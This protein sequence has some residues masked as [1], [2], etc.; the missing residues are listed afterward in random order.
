[1]TCLGKDLREI[2]YSCRETFRGQWCLTVDIITDE[3]PLSNISI[4][5]SGS[6]DENFSV[7]EVNV[8]R[9]MQVISF[10]MS[11]L[12]SFNLCRSK[13]CLIL[14]VVGTSIQLWMSTTGRYLLFGG[15]RYAGRLGR[16]F[17]A[18]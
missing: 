15:T 9:I 17:T 4:G 1:M 16:R 14:I 11:H 10:L 2:V 13:T 7:R 18:F 12:E 8:F 5:Q 6:T 3:V